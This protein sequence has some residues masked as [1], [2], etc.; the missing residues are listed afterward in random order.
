M[1]NTMEKIIRNTILSLALSLAVF[2]GFGIGAHAFTTTTGTVTSDN[3]KVRKSASISSDQ[4]S[5]V[6]KGATVDIIDEEKDESGTIWYKI[7]VKGDEYGYIRNDL[8]S[9]SGGSSGDSTGGSGTTAVEQKSVEVLAENGTVRQAAGTDKDAVGKLKK[10][11]IVTITGETKG[12]DGKKW[13]EITFG[14]N[15]SKGFVRSD[16]VSETPV[17]ASKSV[18]SEQTDAPSDESASPD[19]IAELGAV[20]D[21][22]GTEDAGDETGEESAETDSQSSGEP[23]APEEIGDGRYSISYDDGTW[24]LNDFTDSE[25][26][27]QMQIPQIVQ[28]AKQA[29]E[30]HDK[31]KSLQKIIFAVGATAAVL[32]VIVIILA[33]RLRD[34][35]YY[36]E[37]E[38]EED[39]DE[40]EE[41]E[42]DRYSAPSKKRSR[43]AARESRRDDDEEEEERPK[44][45]RRPRGEE[46]E[47]RESRRAPSRRAA[48]EEDDE[49]PSRRAAASD[50]ERPSRRPAAPADDERTVRPSR[51]ERPLRRRA[52]DQVEERPSRS[53]EERTVR[54]SR[55]DDDSAYADA[56]YE[57]RQ[58]SERR[59]R[60]DD[61]VQ[62]E[63]STRRAKNFLG[64][65]DDFE[66]EFLDLDDDDR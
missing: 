16:L 6:K 20:D 4:V 35:A 14:E 18:K 24:H 52:D 19:V 3:V 50:D 30:F 45:R 33:L 57:E 12:S 10:G 37:E 42:Y 21:V 59:M 62:E 41:E 47:P 53:V 28:L 38:D 27:Q 11:D 26:P 60:S 13:Y 39:E 22:I 61:A 51:G 54:P 2:I 9:K 64:D 8:V 46:E 36:D 55:R 1:K 49:R 48:V 66:F 56:R 40:D 17:V 43:G 32:L 15:G 29:K 65:D 23:L 7:K 5:S 25:K 31:L 63:P 58:P 34:A 44:G